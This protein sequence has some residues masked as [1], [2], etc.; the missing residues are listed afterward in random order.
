[1][2]SKDKAWSA[3]ENLKVA[4]EQDL[5]WF[6]DIEKYILELE[7]LVSVTGAKQQYREIFPIFA[8][9]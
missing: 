2:N 9:D 3:L 4:K 1:M 8:N 7:N 5:D 6:N